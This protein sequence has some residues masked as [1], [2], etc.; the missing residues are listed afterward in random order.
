MAGIASA[1][2]ALGAPPLAPFVREVGAACELAWAPVD[3][4]LVEVDGDRFHVSSVLRDALAHRL[5]AAQTRARRLALGV[6]ALTE[7]A[8]LFGDVLRARAQAQVADLPDDAQAR[9]VEDGEP[10]DAGNEDARRIA[11]GVE[12]LVDA[13]SR[14]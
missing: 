7:L 8:H 2:A 13:V 12:S 1:A 6:A 11:V 5:R 14:G 3:R 9:V 10:A 4:D